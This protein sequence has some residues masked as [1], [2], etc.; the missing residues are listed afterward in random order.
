LAY[1]AL[2]NNLG[3]FM[4]TRLSATDRIPELHEPL[5]HFQILKR[6]AELGKEMIFLPL[7]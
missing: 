2:N 6:R 4:R 1:A 7:W 3:D 5:N